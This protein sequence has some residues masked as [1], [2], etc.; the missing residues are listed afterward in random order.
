MKENN[1]LKNE[2]GTCVASM[3]NNKGSLDSKMKMLQKRIL[4]LEEEN[5]KLK[6]ENKLYK[7]QQT[8]VKSSSQSNKTQ[9]MKEKVE[10]YHKANKKSMETFFASIQ[11][12][13]VEYLKDSE[14]K[15]QNFTS[16][17]PNT[18]DS[19]VNKESNVQR[20]SQRKI[21]SVG[22]RQTTK[23]TPTS[24]KVFFFI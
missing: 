8:S 14:V 1:N 7:D 6:V 2:M 11:N 9:E 22:T 18:T 21:N 13:L 15:H 4:Q 16:R 12:Q 3:E 19:T 24:S 20:T 17:L 5:K 23:D 10:S